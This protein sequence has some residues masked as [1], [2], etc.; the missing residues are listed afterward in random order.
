MPDVGQHQP[1]LVESADQVL[2]VTGI[3]AGLAADRAVDLGQQG[4]RN[5]HE[6]DAAQRDRGGESGDVA[7]HA[8]AQG[9]QCRAAFDAGI[10]DA[11]HQAFEMVEIL[12]LLAWGKDDGAM[13]D[14]GL[15]E[16]DGK[17]VEMKRAHGFV[18]HDKHALLP[19]DRRHELARAG[20]D[21]L[22]DNDVI[23]TVGEIDRDG[24]G[25]VHDLAS[26]ARKRSI[27]VMTRSTVSSSGLSSLSTVMSAS[28]YIG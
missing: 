26:V 24:F 28:A 23:A 4:R 3:D 17:R 10:E 9:H 25:G 6:I 12:G 1:R 18:G 20:E 7:D 13:G 21:V 19:Q 5:L 8:A 15:L 2:A 14:A 11:V 16:R 22:A 27:Y